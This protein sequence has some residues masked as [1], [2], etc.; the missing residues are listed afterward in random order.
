MYQVAMDP[1][2]LSTGVVGILGF[3]MQMAKA[4]SQAREAVEKFRSASKEVAELLERLAVLETVCKLVEVAAAAIPRQSGGPS[5]ASLGAMSTALLQC[6]E[7]MEALGRLLAATGLD[8]S[9]AR[10]P[11]SRSEAFSR[12]RFVLHRE[13][14]RSMVQDVDHAISLLQFVINVDTW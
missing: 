4:A 6:L 14:V 5:S 7:K 3:A 10:S 1:F 8:S 13:K 2:T 9:R 12:L 11:L